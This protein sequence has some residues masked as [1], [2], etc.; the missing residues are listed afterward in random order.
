MEHYIPMVFLC[1]LLYCSDRKC[2]TLKWVVTL[3]EIEITLS[4]HR[5]ICEPLLLNLKII[6]NAAHLEWGLLYGIPMKY[7][8]RKAKE[9][10]L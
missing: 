1:V 5:F 2:S 6:K 4:E 3:P 9:K 7:I 8:E 10:R